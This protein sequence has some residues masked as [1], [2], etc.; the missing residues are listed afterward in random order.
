MS[1]NTHCANV[2][3]AQ[4]IYI[5]EPKRFTIYPYKESSAFTVAK[6]KEIGLKLHYQVTGEC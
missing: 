3:G 4:N 1:C 6:A 5:P 2:I